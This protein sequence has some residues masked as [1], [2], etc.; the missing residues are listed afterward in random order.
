MPKDILFEISCLIEHI[1]RELLVNVS[2]AIGW[3]QPQS[4]ENHRWKEPIDISKN[5][6]GLSI[7]SRVSVFTI[8]LCLGFFS[9][10]LCPF[11]MKLMSLEQYEKLTKASS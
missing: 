8:L 5:I 2:T 11:Q 1:W 10:K 6:N 7:S 4:Q 9:L 3:Q